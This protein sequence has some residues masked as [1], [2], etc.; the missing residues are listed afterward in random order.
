[1][2]RALYPSSIDMT[3]S[4]LAAARPGVFMCEADVVR[5]G[6]SI[7]FVQGQLTGGEGCVIARA[8]SS[9]MLVPADR[10]S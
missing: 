7:D 8:S 2:E 6:K 5:L 1:M 10:A 9:V 3:V 4:F